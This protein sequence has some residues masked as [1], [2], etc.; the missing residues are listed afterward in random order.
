MA[1]WLPYLLHKAHEVV[2][3]VCDPVRGPVSRGMKTDETLL[4]IVLEKYAMAT[5]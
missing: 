1:Y 5:S 4:L 3:M 2:V